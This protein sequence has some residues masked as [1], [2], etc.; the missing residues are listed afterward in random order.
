MI[1][2]TI[3]KICKEL[4][5][6]I[7]TT[8]SNFYKLVD[9]LASFLISKLQAKLHV[10]CVKKN[11]DAHRKVVQKLSLR[12]ID[13]LKLEQMLKPLRQRSRLMLKWKKKD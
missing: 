11:D 6:Y 1:K 2:N 8:I 10:A 3:S 4:C 13:K 5:A 9:T 7:Y 12:I